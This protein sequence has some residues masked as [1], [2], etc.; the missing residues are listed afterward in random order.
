MSSNPKHVNQSKFFATWSSKWSFRAYSPIPHSISKRFLHQHVGFQNVNSNISKQFINYYLFFIVSSQQRFQPGKGE[1]CVDPLHSLSKIFPSCSIG[2][3]PRNGSHI[4]QF[5]SFTFKQ[6]SS[7]I[8]H[9]AV[10]HVAPVRVRGQ[11]AFHKF[12]PQ[13]L[14]P[15]FSLNCRQHYV[16]PLEVVFLSTPHR[17]SRQN[18]RK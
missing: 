14:L 9:G 13:R 17:I 6:P 18:L 2:K 16:A 4:L 7:A 8:V 5:K 1:H 11:V 12:N 10:V 3:H 15:T